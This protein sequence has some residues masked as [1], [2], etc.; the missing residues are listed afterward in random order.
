MAET[1][2]TF[3]TYSDRAYPERLREIFNPPV[4]LWIRG[5]VELLS[6]P[7]IAV[8]GARH[9]RLMALAWP[10][11]TSRD[12]AAHGVDTAAH[13]R[14][15]AVAIWRTGVDVIYPKE[16]KSPAGQIT[17]DGDAIVSHISRAAESP[18]TQSHPERNCHRRC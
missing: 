3:L 10:R 6:Q 13:Q 4:L 11:C 17:A 16:N 15:I 2:A 1:G 14:A 5:N 8:V 7:S 9:P 12:P 18:Q